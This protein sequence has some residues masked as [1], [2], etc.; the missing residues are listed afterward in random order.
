M[1]KLFCLLAACLAGFS[2]EAHKPTLSINLSA[3]KNYCDTPKLDC[4]C[5]TPRLERACPTPKN[6]RFCETP[7][8]DAQGFYPVKEA[9]SVCAVC[10]LKR[11]TA[12]K[13]V[14]A[15]DCDTPVI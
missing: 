13:N 2:L 11:P 15:R 9:S 4:K 14:A 12:I 8:L 5:D 1:K 3:I 6:L 10:S 7:E